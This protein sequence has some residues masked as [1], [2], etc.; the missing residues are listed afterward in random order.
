MTRRMD[1]EIVKSL[2][3]SKRKAYMKLVEVMDLTTQL[4]QAIER[5]DEV[6]TKMLLSM[7][8]EPLLALE[9][10]E[11]TVRGGVLRQ[12]AQDARRLSLLLRGSPVENEDESE[13]ALR[14]ICER[15][16]RE[17]DRIAQ[18]DRRLSLKLGGKR[19]YYNNVR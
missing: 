16:R 13:T 1:Y 19:S 7:R 14:E 18:L 17:L 9:E 8:R 3:M 6:S 2:Q 4:A 5:R 12:P 15:N 10:I 11:E